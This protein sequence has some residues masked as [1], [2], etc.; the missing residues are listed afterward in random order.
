MRSVTATGFSVPIVDIAPTLAAGCPVGDVAEQIDR[1]C[2]DVGFF[3]IVGH[4][5]DDELRADVLS[6]ARR[7]FALPDSEKRALAIERSPNNR[8]YAGIAGERLQPDLPADLKETFDVGLELTADGGELSPLDGPNQW[9]AIAGFRD[10]LER[11]QDEAIEIARTLMSVI[12]TAN[13]LP[14]DHFTACLRRPIVTTRLLRYPRV[15][16]PTTTGQLGCGA[17]SDYGCLTLLYAD[18]T[19]GLQ[20]MTVDDEW[21]DVTVPDGALIVNLGDL[22]QRWTNDRYRST[23]HR[24]IPPT[25]RDRYSVPVFV[26]PEWSTLVRCLPTCTSDERP[27]RHAPVVSG[28]YLQSRYDDTFVYRGDAPALDSRNVHHAE[29]EHSCEPNCIR[30]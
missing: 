10:T 13:H 19:P 6:L 16:Q 22:L 7:F 25:E 29:T 11:Y 3:A 23:R 14:G 18:G 2:C 4:G 28:E 21:V 24:V 15:D 26:N 30:P 20:L 17:H 27:A 9:P 5:V 1:A 12:A 8:G